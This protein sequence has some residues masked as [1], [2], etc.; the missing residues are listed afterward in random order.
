MALGAETREILRLVVGGGM[1][2][3][4]AGIV[5]GLPMAMAAGRWLRSLLFETSPMDPLSFG[6]IALLLGATAFVASYVPARR[7]ARL[8]PLDA[9]RQ[10]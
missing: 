2:L 9:L 1:K 6:G 8:D 10:E 3:T 7:A 4:L 5:L